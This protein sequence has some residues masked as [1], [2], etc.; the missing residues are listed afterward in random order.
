MRRS[1]EEEEEEEKVQENVFEIA[2]NTLRISSG[3]WTPTRQGR[4]DVYSPE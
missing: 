4:V 2:G 3:I 1:E